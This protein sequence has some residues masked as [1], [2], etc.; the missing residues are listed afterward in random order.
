MKITKSDLLAI[1]RRFNEADEAH[2]PR[3]IDQVVQSHP[4]PTN[5]LVGF[6][7]VRK[8]YFVLFD[9]S[10]ED[11]QSY[12]FEQVR[13]TKSDA[14]GDLLKN[15]MSHIE[16]YGLPFKGKDVYLFRQETGKERLDILLSTRNPSINRSTWQKY[17]KAGYVSVDGRIVKKASQEV[18]QTATVATTIPKGSDYSNDELPIIYLDDTVIVADKPAGIL[19]HSKGVMNDELTVA[20]FF[21]RYTTVG[22]DGNRPGIVHRL[23][24][25]TS[26][27]IIGARTPE[28]AELLKHQFAERKAKKTYLA[29]VEGIPKHSE[30][31]IDIPLAR[32]PAAPGTFRADP[33]G[34]PAQTNYR[35][36]A[37]RAGTSLVL[38]QPKTGRTHQLRVHMAQLDHPIVGDR[39]YGT[40]SA[41]LYLHAYQLEITTAPEQRQTF[42][43][44]IPKEFI[45]KF[46]EAADVANIS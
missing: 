8:H 46:P 42:A 28:S 45:D 30:A 7:F 10:A 3:M 13:L 27:I 21:R 38:L 6:R 26:G 18:G 40:P 25:D 15:P 12:I 34:K 14:D 19:T 29:I 4:S 11:D 35:V 32:N 17:I 16:T 24:R 2:T 22:L 5:Q 36:L 9:E 41:R 23:D 37:S 1:L 20:E 33:K 31:Q 39:V 43:A 44:P